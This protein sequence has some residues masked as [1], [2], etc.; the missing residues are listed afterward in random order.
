[1]FW[2]N[3]YSTTQYWSIT[4]YIMSVIV[5][6]DWNTTTSSTYWVSVN[7]NNN[8]LVSVN[9]ALIETLEQSINFWNSIYQSVIQIVWW[10]FDP[11]V[12]SVVKISVSWIDVVSSVLAWKWTAWIWIKPTTILLT[13]A[14][15]TSKNYV[16]LPEKIKPSII[17]FWADSIIV[18][19]NWE[20]TLASIKWEKINILK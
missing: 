18:Q 9:S 4:T 13:I 15:P 2:T 8:I 14:I 1:M 11:R 16:F 10:L 20:K 3:I 17:W 6:D 5:V 7:S 19:A 12:T